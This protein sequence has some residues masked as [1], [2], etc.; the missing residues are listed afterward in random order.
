MAII[1]CAKFFVHCINLNVIE[2]LLT[3]C[4]SLGC[5][6]LF[7]Y[8]ICS[9]THTMKRWLSTSPLTRRRTIV[10]HLICKAMDEFCTK[11]T[12]TIKP[13]WY[14]HRR[15]NCR[16]LVHGKSWIS[17]KVTIITIIMN[18]K[19]NWKTLLRRATTKPTHHNSNYSKCS[20]KVRL[21][22]YFLCV[23]LWE[24]MLACCTQWR[25]VISLTI[26]AATAY[27]VYLLN[28]FSFELTFVGAEKSNAQ[29]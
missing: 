14:W 19:L 10:F 8:V 2:F 28:H 18:M 25:W 12:Q 29:N 6:L 9:R 24:K 16:C 21:A 3:N 15:Q 13:K 7:F 5:V 17:S 4:V 26:A 22:K 1:S 11:P 27:H 23:K 20:A